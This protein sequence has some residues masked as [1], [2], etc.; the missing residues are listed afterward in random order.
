MIKKVYISDLFGNKIDKWFYFD[1]DINIV[2]GINGAGKTTFLK[3]VWYLIS[4]NIERVFREI[5]V[6]HVILVHSDFTLEIDSKKLS[7]VSVSYIDEDINRNE[8]FDIS[9]EVI[10]YDDDTFN[11]NTRIKSSGDKAHFFLVNLNDF[12]HLVCSKSKSSLF[13]PTFRRIEGGFSMNKGI[14]NP[15]GLE[16][17]RFIFEENNLDI[18]RA[19]SEMTQKVSVENHKLVASIST[20][21]IIELLSKEY[22]KKSEKSTAI[23]NSLTEK[24]E[25][26][27]SNNF[28]IDDEMVNAIEKKNEIFE[29]VLQLLNDSKEKKE[30]L[31]KPFGILDGFIKKLFQHKGIIID[32]N[33][34]IGSAKDALMSEKL[35]AGEKQMLSFICYN[36]FI[37][38]GI[39]FIDEPEIS[40]HVDWQR[41]IIKTL[42]S[43]NSNNQFVIATHSPFIYSQY[44]EYE[45]LLN[46]SRGDD[47]E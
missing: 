15:Y 35:S 37:S 29:E 24:I 6:E 22:I 39:I 47:N 11:S 8:I 2:T 28:A 1:K 45:L 9:N 42:M 19:L 23:N 13:F 43:Q 32:D 12:N 27:I 40:L 33:I 4:G 10:E 7:E 25:D 21:D 38:N 3:L 31:D 26:K 36:A 30:V 44:E 14:S 34:V 41:I 18:N 46:E 20:S 16:I 5:K 17:P